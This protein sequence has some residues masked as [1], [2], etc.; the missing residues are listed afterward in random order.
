MVTNATEGY[1]FDVFKRHCAS[2]MVLD[3]LSGK[4]TYLTVTA[5][6][7]GRMRNAELARKIEGISPKMLS[8]TLRGLEHDGLV[9]RTVHAEVPPRV[10]YELTA[11]GE[12]L[13]GLMDQICIWAQ[14][15][16]PEILTHRAANGD[17]EAQERL[18]AA[19]A[20]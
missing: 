16:V 17:P 13:A 12:E 6:R 1:T 18:A 11:L 4:W 2:H 8:Q 7:Q 19:G 14:N 3:L 15:H 9:S 5:L 20:R 10:D